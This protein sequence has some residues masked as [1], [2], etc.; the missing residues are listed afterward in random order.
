MLDFPDGAGQ[1]NLES[2]PTKLFE[3]MAAGRPF[4]AS[5]FAYW[6]GLFGP[7]NCGL[8]VDPCDPVAIRGA[9]EALATDLPMAEAMGLRGRSAF[10]HHFTFETQATPLY[11]AVERL[12]RK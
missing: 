12:L 10:E 5:H 2:Q 7:F 6:V 9:M 11:N 8:F 1:N 4:V 3:Y